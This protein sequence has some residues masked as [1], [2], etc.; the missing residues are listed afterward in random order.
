MSIKCKAIWLVVAVVAMLSC[1]GKGTDTSPTSSLETEEESLDSIPLQEE[2]EEEPFLVEEGNPQLDGIFNDFLFAYLHSR[3]LRR[4]RTAKPLRLEHPERPAEM[5]EQFD[6]EF[7]FG[8]LSGEYFTTLYGNVRQMQAEDDEELEEDSI[9]SLQRI[10]LNDGTIRNFQFLREE[11]RWQL[12]G[13]LE[14]T[15]QD[16]DLC[17]FLTFYARFCTDSLFQAQAI[18]DPL[19]I[20]IQDTEDEEGCIDGIIDADQWQTFC[21]EVPSGIISNIRKGQSYGGNRIVLRKSGLS[22][23]LQE[24]FT[25]TRERGNWRLT[26]YEN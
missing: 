7:E 14:A 25:F 9:V 4:E 2:I 15:F 16:D 21:P 12:D 20:V 24:V 22:N 5:L 19:R 18:A 6:A 23:G 13:I 3:T 17:D 10:N 1:G 8:F 26:K 11:G